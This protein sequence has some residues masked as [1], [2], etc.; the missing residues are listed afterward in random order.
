MSMGM[1]SV[2]AAIAVV[3]IAG[4]I[5]GI[6]R[7][8]DNGFPRAIAAEAAKANTGDMAAFVFKADGAAVAPEFRFLDGTGKDHTL[9]DWKGR[10]VLL[11]LWATWCQ[12]CRKEMPALDRLQADLG[13]TDFEVVAIAV[14][15]AGAPAAQKFLDQ[16]GTKKLALYVDP[17]ARLA[18]E[19]RAIGLPATIL[20]GR[21]G[22]EI[23][24]LLGPAEWDG[25]D[26]KRLIAS[27]SGK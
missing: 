9:A 1:K 19:L 4:G 15:R 27:V 23:G 8:S 5:Y 10:V 17:S 21:D 25:V 14:D 2:A 20:I 26:A 11:N 22:R 6:G 3:I 13:G 18:T 24:R 12:P 16:V 7:Q